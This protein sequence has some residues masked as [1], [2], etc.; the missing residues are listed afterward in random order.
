MPLCRLREAGGEAGMWGG[1]R[2]G[3]SGFWGD[4]RNLTFV[5]DVKTTGSPVEGTLIRPGAGFPFNEGEMMCSVI[6]FERISATHGNYQETHCSFKGCASRF[7]MLYF[8][9]TNV[10]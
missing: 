9:D 7:M 3:G 6:R 8:C 2:L 10:S 4:E 5:A 1:W